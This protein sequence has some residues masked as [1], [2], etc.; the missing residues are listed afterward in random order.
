MPVF[1]DPSE[2]KK[3]SLFPDDIDAIP[4][5]GLE[6]ATG[7]D[8]VIARIPVSP[9]A[10]LDSHIRLKSLFCQRKSGYDAIGDFNQIWLEIGRMKSKDIPM[11]QCFILPIGKFYGDQD[12]L[13][14]IEGKKP[15]KNSERITY[16]T[17]LKN[18]AEWGYSGMQVRRLN[19]EGELSLFV[20]AQTEE[21]ER[22]ENRDSVK[23]VFSKGVAII[24]DDP[25]QEVREVDDWR[26]LFLNGIKGIG[27]KTLDS[28]QEYAQDDLPGA[29]RALQYIVNLDDKGK[30]LHRIGG[31][32]TKTIS[33][34]RKMLGLKDGQ[35]IYVR[36]FDCQ[37]EFN[38][39]WRS[40]LDSFREM[41][42]AGKKKPAEIWKQL[43]DEEIPF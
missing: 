6:E 16:L 41:L 21:L 42:E 43:R 25:F 9:V 7:A 14:R 4:C 32:G 5:P 1:V 34:I 23:E 3:N 13:L 17:Y 15:L 24:P 38:A 20:Q 36:D 29:F 30:S 12:G 35:N 39:G 2:L 22:I 18:E 8:F 31:I 33:N 11:M 19:D 27:L 26:N 10:F 28:I 40:A 37:T